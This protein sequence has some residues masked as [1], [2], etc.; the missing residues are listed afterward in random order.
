MEWPE[1]RK[2]TTKERTSKKGKLSGKYQEK[3]EEFKNM[4]YV[5]V[6]KSLK[7]GRLYV[8]HTNNLI[9]RFKEHNIG[10]ENSTKNRKPFKLLYYEGS[11]ILIDAI[12]REKS[13]KT[14]FGRRYLKNRLSDI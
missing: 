6:L 9:R 13:L 2:N 1:A 10:L 5:Y 7:D 14:G 12:K 11:N 8:G 3:W 4:Y